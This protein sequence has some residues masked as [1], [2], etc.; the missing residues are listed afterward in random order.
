VAVC[1]HSVMPTST[2]LSIAVNED[3]AVSALATVPRGASS[4]LVF[5]HGAGAGMNHPFIV[6]VCDGLAER[7]MATLRYQ[8]PY[9]EKGS[10]RP[11][12][13]RLC[14]KTV[15]RAIATAHE[16]LPKLPLF[17]GGKSFGGRMTS[18]AQALAPLAQVR[19]LC[20]FGFPLHAAGKPS[21]AR[22]DHLTSIDVPMLFLQGTRDALAELPL[23]QEVVK[24]L[25]G[26]ATLEVI[27][28]A[29]HSFHVLVRSGTTDSGVMELM[30]DDVAAWAAR[31]ITSE[32]GNAGKHM[33]NAKKTTKT[34][35]AKKSKPSGR[36]AHGNPIPLRSS[37]KASGF[38]NPKDTAQ[39]HG[40]MGTG[41]MGEEHK[42][43]R[44]TRRK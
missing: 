3:T 40:E 5:A 43:A 20:F 25:S 38:S 28:H 22:A 34:K 27:D 15:Q 1:I 7:S 23:V 16:L 42:T 9:M 21:T 12:S 37:T 26:R 41:S 32:I 30:L 29:D 33:V 36:D 24:R 18:R 39:R 6:A 4:C 31:V 13:P 14:R 35:K 10:G 44:K 8:F 17:A 11:D 19:G 2:Q